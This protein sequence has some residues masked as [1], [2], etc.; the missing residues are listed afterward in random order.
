[1]EAFLIKRGW[2]VAG[3]REAMAAQLEADVRDA[4]TRQEAIAMPELGSL[5]EDVYEAPPWHLREQMS[6]LAAAERQQSPHKHG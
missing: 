4:I 2:L 1:M 6:E 5:V 3:E